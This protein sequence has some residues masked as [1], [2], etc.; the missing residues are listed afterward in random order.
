MANPSKARGPW[1]FGRKMAAWIS[2]KGL[3]VSGFAEAHGF[4]QRT[5][6]G[7]VKEGVRVPDRALATIA[8]ATGLPVDYWLD[9]SLP[10]PAPVDYADL[11]GQVAEALKAVSLDEL[12]EILAMLRDPDDRRRTLAMRRAARA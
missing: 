4:K 10:F 1:P 2:D 3:S 6:H 9:D 8:R 12:R 11:A 7:W 5:F